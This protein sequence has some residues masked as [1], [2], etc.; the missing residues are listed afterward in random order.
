MKFLFKNFEEVSKELSI[1]LN[2]RPHNLSNLTYY[3][4]CSYYEKLVQ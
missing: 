3:K 4:I 1:D 2:L